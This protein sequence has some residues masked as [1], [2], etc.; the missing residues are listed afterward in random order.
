[1]KMFNHSLDAFS[2][3]AQGFYRYNEPA[4]M[5]WFSQNKDNVL[6]YLKLHVDCIELDVSDYM[7]YIEFF[8]DSN[9]SNSINDQAVQRLNKL[10][11]SIP[12]CESYQSQGIWFL[13]SGLAPSIDDSRKKIPKENLP[14]K[15]D[16]E[17]N[18]VWKNIIDSYYLSDSYYIYEKSWYDLR[19]NALCF[20]K[21]FSKGLQNILVGKKFDFQKAFDGGKLPD[22]LMDSLRYSPD[23]PA[24]APVH[25][26][27]AL[28]GTPNKWSTSLQNFLS[29]IFEYFQDI[30][31]QRIGRLAV[32]NFQYAVKYIPEMHSVFKHL[33]ENVPDYFELSELDI[34]EE[35][36]Y[37]IFADLLDVWIIE[38]PKTPQRN[39]MQY[40]RKRREQKRQEM[41][42]SIQDVI[43]SLKEYGMIIIPPI[44]AYINHP[45]CYLPLAFSVEDPIYPEA[46]LDIVIE[47]ISEVKDIADFFC[48]VPIH[49]GVR[50]LKGG[51]QIS[52]NQITQLNEGQSIN[53][54]AFALQE[55]SEDILRCLPT[56]PFRPSVRLQIRASITSL[57]IGMKAFI[58]QKNNIETLRTSENQFEVELYNRH[59]FRLLEIQ[60]DFCIVASKT[61]D[62][63]KAEYSSLQDD[64]DFKTLIGFLEI[65]EEA[66]QKD[67]IDAQFMS[68][69]FKADDIWNATE[70]LLQK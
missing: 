62:Y 20:V 16:V 65:I 50:F 54:E 21:A 1:M 46:S 58:E 51:Y 11:S 3:F 29:Q 2:I 33:F 53:W 27:K 8:T 9:E 57:L 18:V 44:D 32:H 52:S 43:A 7:L 17:K 40:I 68:S 59:E 56:L 60:A 12:F 15:S 39:I 19:N 4:Y 41:L 5:K 25:L 35:K 69:D 28:K 26:S 61:M 37:G 38:P 30:S 48:L 55:L 34:S 10:R 66:S 67:T 64:T 70:Q 23:P 13:P 45:L 47:A 49:E 36:D 31:K 24:Q 22:R 63:L 42:S 6:G 14:F